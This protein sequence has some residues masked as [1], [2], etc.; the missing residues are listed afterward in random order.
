MLEPGT[1]LKAAMQR[2]QGH[3]RDHRPQHQLE[4]RLEHLEGEYHQA[5]HQTRLDQHI[6]QA[7]RQRTVKLDTRLHAAPPNVLFAV[8]LD[9]VP[10]FRGCQR[11]WYV[12]Q[13]SRQGHHHQRHHGHRQGD[14]QYQQVMHLW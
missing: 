4:E 3:R 1:A 14:G 6:E 7:P 5:G 10:R 2:V 13:P 12:L 11:R 9:S 8:C